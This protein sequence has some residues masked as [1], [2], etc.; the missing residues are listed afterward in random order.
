[1]TTPDFSNMSQEAAEVASG[2]VEPD[3]LDDS[4]E[5]AVNERKEFERQALEYTEA[6][7][8]QY[9]ITE[10]HLIEAIYAG[11]LAYLINDQIRNAAR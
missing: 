4:I 6:Y 8:E 5:R 2:N 10:E 3:T 1:M 11:H 7:Q 9:D